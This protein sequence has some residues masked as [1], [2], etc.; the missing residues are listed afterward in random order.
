MHVPAKRDKQRIKAG[1]RR[2]EHSCGKQGAIDPVQAT[3]SLS[4]W[5]NKTRHFQKLEVG[6]A[7]DNTFRVVRRLL[8]PAGENLKHITKLSHGAKVWI[9]GHGSRRFES[10]RGNDSG[11]L[12]ICISACTRSSLDK[13][14]E[15]VQDLLQSTHEDY[16]SFRSSTVKTATAAKLDT[17]TG[18]FKV[19][20]EEESPFQVVKRIMGKGGRN[21]KRIEA[22]TWASVQIQGRKTQKCAEVQPPLEVHVSS[23]SQESFDAATASMTALLTRIHADYCEF[24]SLK[25][26]AAPALA[27][28]CQAVLD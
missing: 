12:S 13:A 11:P 22:E 9:C 23:A 1:K 4:G 18:C 3:N 16:N 14:S 15:L 17:F 26:V 28:V 8:G 24:C 7:D 27:V 6:I 20:I 25:G 5:Q 10:Q 2:L 19:G 21:L